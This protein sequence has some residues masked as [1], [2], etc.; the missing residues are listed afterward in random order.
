MEPNSQNKVRDIVADIK[1]RRQKA[2]KEGLKKNKRYNQNV[3]KEGE[4]VLIQDN[5]TRKWEMKGRI[6]KPRKNLGGRGPK[7]YIVK[8]EDGS[9]YLRNVRYIARTPPAVT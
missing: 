9:E 5:K 1:A 8:T 6:E 2:L 4:E 7:S 3:F